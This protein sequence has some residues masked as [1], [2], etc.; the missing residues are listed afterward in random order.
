MNK[1]NFNYLILE[2][3]GSKRAF[4]RAMNSAKY[5]IS[6]RALCMYCHSTQCKSM[7]I[8]RAEQ[9]SQVLNMPVESLVRTIINEGDE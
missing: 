2:K 9:I 8:A 3:F 7:T 6:Y 4:M 5:P 1:T